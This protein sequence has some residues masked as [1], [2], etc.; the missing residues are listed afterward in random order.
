[1]LSD[2]TT[3]Q[4]LDDRFRETLAALAAPSQRRDPARPVT[5]DTTLTGAQALDLFDAQVTS[6]QL[7]LAGRWLRSFGEGYYTIGSAGHE[8]NAAVAA[9]LRATDPALLH[10]RSGAFYC[11]RAAQAAG[12]TA[13][14]RPRPRP[15]RAG[16]RA[17]RGRPALRA[18]RR[19]RRAVRRR[20]VRR[21]AARHRRPAAADGPVEAAPAD[22]D[23]PGDGSAPDA[24]DPGEPT[25]GAGSAVDRP[26][27]P[28]YAEAA[29][30][31]LRGMVASSQRAD[32]RRPA[33]GLRPGRP[34]RR[35]DHLHHRLAPAPRGRD[36]AGRGTAA[37][38]GHRRPAR[39][40][41]PAGSGAGATHAAWPPD[42]IVVCSF[43]DASVNHASATAAFNTAGWY[44]HTGLRIPV[45]FVCEDNGLGISVRSPKGWVEATLRSKPGHP[46]LRRRRRRPGRGRTR[47]RPRRRPGCAGTG[48][49]PC[50][51]CRPY[52]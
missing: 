29:R 16:S 43:G 3:P 6:R 39:T 48:A 34:G 44:D 45:L 5:D 15:T 30:D 13:D 31:V 19:R 35:P 11:V 52:G 28:G 25:G 9:A 4:D 38:A 47:W 18:S 1:M 24:A 42:A 2:V 27:H 10:Y 20:A 26:F 36:G 41:V 23:G 12:W 8:G 22:P 51:T 7:D 14:R 21:R 33:Q 49:R 50:C 17:T 37:P 32:R 46:L 40:G